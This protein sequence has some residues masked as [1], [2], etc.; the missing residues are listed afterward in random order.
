MVIIM[1]TRRLR[2]SIDDEMLLITMN[3]NCCAGRRIYRYV[4]AYHRHVTLRYASALS[5]MITMFVTPRHVGQYAW[6]TRLLRLLIGCYVYIASSGRCLANCLTTARRNTQRRFA[7]RLLMLRH[8]I[9]SQ[10]VAVAGYGG[11]A[12]ALT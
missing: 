6:F 3:V 2:H 8:V 4:D 9:T 1:L 11:V 12:M 7:L 10:Q 5:R